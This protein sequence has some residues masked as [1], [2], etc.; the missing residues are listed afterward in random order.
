MISDDIKQEI[1]NYNQRDI[2][3]LYLYVSE[4]YNKLKEQ[5]AKKLS[6]TLYAVKNMD[7]MNKCT[8]NARQKQKLADK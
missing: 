3:R 4:K 8:Q 1:D 6:R 2:V 7:I 5:D